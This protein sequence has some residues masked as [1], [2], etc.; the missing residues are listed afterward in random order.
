MDEFDDKI[1]RDSVSVFCVRWEIMVGRDERDCEE[2]DGRVWWERGFEYLDVVWC[3]DYGDV[4][5]FGFLFRFKQG[6]MQTLGTC[7]AKI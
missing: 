4:V 3:V 1:V 5:V 6:R 7:G 2:I